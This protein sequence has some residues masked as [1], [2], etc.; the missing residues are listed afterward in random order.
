MSDPRKKLELLAQFYD[1]NGYGGSL[2][3]KNDNDYY[4]GATE[5]YKEFVSKHRKGNKYTMAQIGEMWR[6]SK[7]DDTPIVKKTIIKKTNKKP[8]K[9][10]IKEI[11]V[12]SPKPKKFNKNDTIIR[13]EADKKKVMLDAI[14]SLIEVYNDMK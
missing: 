10:E 12:V 6:K 7:D 2:L 4:G 9:N 1:E 5:T 8:I 13:S 14:L 11:K 3:K